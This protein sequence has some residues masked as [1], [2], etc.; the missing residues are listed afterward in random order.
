MQNLR[1][2]Q[3]TPEVRKCCGKICV[4]IGIPAV[5]LLLLGGLFVAIAKAPSNVYR[6]QHCLLLNYTCAKNFEN[7][8]LFDKK[9]NVVVV[10]TNKTY[11]SNFDVYQQKSCG[12]MRSEIGETYDCYVNSV[13]FLR[14]KPL[15]EDYKKKFL[16]ISICMFSFGAPLSFYSIVYLVVE[17]Y[18]STKDKKERRRKRKALEDE[19]KYDQFRPA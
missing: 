7:S 15:D 13:D 1:S 3:C 2:F 5:I 18:Y 6:K 9:W 19:T 14:W 17:G 8:N 11:S 12:E 10:E 4:I 16:L